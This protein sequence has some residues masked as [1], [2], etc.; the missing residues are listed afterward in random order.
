MAH[1]GAWDSKGSTLDLAKSSG[2][3]A[4][5]VCALRAS[6]ATTDI[7]VADLER[8]YSQADSTQL[9]VGTS[10]ATARGWVKVT[11]Q[12]AAAIATEKGQA[13]LTIATELHSAFKNINGS[14]EKHC[15]CMSCNP[16]IW[17]TLA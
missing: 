14:S 6:E 11:A 15:P 2:E 1:D 17:K 10:R 5:M 3:W 8:M 16:E 7:P 4:L 9:L 13:K 12:I